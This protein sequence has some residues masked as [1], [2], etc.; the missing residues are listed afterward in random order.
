VQ[1]CRVHHDHVIEA[2]TPDRANDAFPYAERFVRAIKE[3][4]L[5]R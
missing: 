4:C 5:E 3:E 1:S 2:F